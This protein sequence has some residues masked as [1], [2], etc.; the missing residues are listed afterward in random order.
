MPT[1]EEYRRWSI[2][3][4]LHVITAAIAVI[5]SSNLNLLLL[6]LQQCCRDVVYAVY[7]YMHMLY[8][9]S[10]R[11]L[12]KQVDCFNIRKEKKH[13]K[14]EKKAQEEEDGIKSRNFTFPVTLSS[15]Q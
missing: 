8:I 4:L 5:P 10:S 14:E 11:F 2:Q 1:K 3:I 12:F 6:S 9:H 13:D 15:E 7:M